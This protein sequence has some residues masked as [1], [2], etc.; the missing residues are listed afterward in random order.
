FFTQLWE[1]VKQL[2]SAAWTAVQGV[3]AVVSEWFNRTVVQPVAGF[4]SGLWQ[5]IQQ[6]AGTVWEAVKGLWSAAAGWFSQHVPQPLSAA[7][8]VAGGAIKNTI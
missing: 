7:F 4:F 1:S 8:D 2:A 3:W 6:G 5:G